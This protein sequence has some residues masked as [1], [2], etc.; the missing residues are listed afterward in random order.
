MLEGVVRGWVIQLAVFAIS[1]IFPLF[2]EQLLLG[3]LFVSIALVV[4]EFQNGVLLCW[5]EGR[6]RQSLYG[7]CGRTFHGGDSCV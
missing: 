1:E 4:A 7:L 6:R 3:L 5:V 2:V